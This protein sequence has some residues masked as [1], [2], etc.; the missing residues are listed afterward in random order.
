MRLSLRAFK[1]KAGELGRAAIKDFSLKK[2][3]RKSSDA[4]ILVR[5]PSN[6]ATLCFLELSADCGIADTTSP[7]S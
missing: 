1:K 4:N 5:S 2:F 7:V 3:K 6:V